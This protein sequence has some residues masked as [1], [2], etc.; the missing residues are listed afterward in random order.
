MNN[1][2]IDCFER[3]EKSLHCI[4]NK[5]PIQHF[6]YDENSSFDGL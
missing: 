3:K 1:I 2:L 4:N 5:L 6:G